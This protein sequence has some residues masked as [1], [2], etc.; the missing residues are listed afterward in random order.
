[1]SFDNC[2]E[3]YQAGRANIPQG[4]P[5]YAKK[6]DRDGDGVACDNPPP[7]FKPA[8]ETETSTGTKVENGAGNGDQL[9]KTGPAAELGGAGAV[10]L[11]IGMIAAVL[12]RRRRTRF[13]A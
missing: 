10:L 5:D 13:T 3:A 7:G 1:M 9:P 2:T 12:F 4:D 8:R 6:L 11:A